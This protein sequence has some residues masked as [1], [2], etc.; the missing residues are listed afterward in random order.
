MSN[1]LLNE[2]PK[3]EECD[4]IKRN[5][6][7]YILTNESLLGI[8]F[9]CSIT[10]LDK[11]LTVAGS[12]E[13]ALRFLLNGAQEI[14]MFDSNPF[15]IAHCYLLFTLLESEDI[16]YEEFIDFF[17]FSDHLRR[18]QELRS[19]PSRYLDRDIYNKVRD[20]L[21]ESI[22]SIWDN[23]VNQHY[24]LYYSFE[25]SDELI[26][27]PN[28]HQMLEKTKFYEIK[29]RLQSPETK[30]NFIY[31]NLNDMYLPNTSDKQSTENPLTLISSI[32]N[33]DVDI[34]CL[35]NIQD[36]YWDDEQF[37]RIVN[38]IIKSHNPKIV[39]SYISPTFGGCDGYYAEKEKDKYE[40]D[41]LQIYTFS[42]SPSLTS[43]ATSDYTIIVNTK[44]LS[45]QELKKFNRLRYFLTNRTIDR[46][47]KRVK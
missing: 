19:I 8:D 12:G 22:Q 7:T 43:N 31:S 32:L 24:E 25:H 42:S 27:N 14:T 38:N 3:I 18:F 6:I 39:V 47:P 46:P 4:Q 37:F 13:Q 11:V 41:D 44:R 21:P 17:G 5:T 15:A 29:Q 10:P 1:I 35:S 20:K 16:T 40:N 26:Q 33:Q 28:I 36:W 23:Y 2:L 34:V 45:R 30:I 9:L